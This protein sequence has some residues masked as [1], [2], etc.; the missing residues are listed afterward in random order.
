M[1]K[2]YYSAQEISEFHRST[3]LTCERELW[4]AVLSQA[5]EDLSKPASFPN[6]AIRHWF[7]S[8][9]Q[10][11]GSFIWICGQLEIE[12]DAAR[13]RI[14][15]ASNNKLRA[16]LQCENLPSMQVYQTITAPR[17][18]A[19]NECQNESQTQSAPANLARQVS[20]GA[21]FPG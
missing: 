1:N 21:I 2:K 18:E 14:L 8:P 3:G 9:N 12:A 19:Q 5:I 15:R 7:L 13:K 11:I 17:Y 4:G 10:Q 20:N 16:R 6:Q